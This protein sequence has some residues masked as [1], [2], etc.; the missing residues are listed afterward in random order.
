[1]GSLSTKSLFE[2]LASSNVDPHPVMEPKMS[3]TSAP[4]APQSVPM[5]ASLAWIN[6]EYRNPDKSGWYPVFVKYL[7][8]D[9]PHTWWDTNSWWRAHWDGQ[10]WSSCEPVE[11]DAVVSFWLDGLPI[12]PAEYQQHEQE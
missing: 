3:P 7:D 6:A 11:D 5:A 2:T 1:M 10:R 4:N 8:D 9:L 12:L